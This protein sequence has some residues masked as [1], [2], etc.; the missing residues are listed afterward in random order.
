M[1][2]DDVCVFCP[3]EDNI[4]P[5]RTV[6]MFGGYQCS[7]QALFFSAVPN[8]KEGRN[9]ELAQSLKYICGCEGTGYAGASSNIKRVVLAWL[10]RVV[11]VASILVSIDCLLFRYGRTIRSLLIVLCVLFYHPAR[12]HHL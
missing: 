12:V 2:Q 5:N 8:D 4:Y 1:S 11:A 9:C 6:P 10:P 3:K 7:E